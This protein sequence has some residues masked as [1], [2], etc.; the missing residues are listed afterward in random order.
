MNTSINKIIKNED[1]YT[2]F[3]M[4]GNPLGVKRLWNDLSVS[5]KIMVVDYFK[6]NG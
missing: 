2:I 1:Y 5:E 4:N 6:N 3:Y